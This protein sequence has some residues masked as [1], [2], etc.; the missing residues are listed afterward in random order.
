MTAPD[1]R[2]FPRRKIFK[3]PDSQGA[4]FTRFKLSRKNGF[5]ENFSKEE[6][7]LGGFFPKRN[8]YPESLSRKNLI[9]EESS[10]REIL[11]W[12]QDFRGENFRGARF[13][14]RKISKGQ[15][16]RGERFQK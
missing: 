13:Q 2:G 15:D 5:Q 8:L 14:R 7:F 6:S 4:R 1:F 12:M 16:F 9:R 11:P 3:A 10:S